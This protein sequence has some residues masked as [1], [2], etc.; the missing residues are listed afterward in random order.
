M[1]RLVSAGALVRDQLDLFVPN[2][3]T[4][5]VGVQAVA[6]SVRVFV[7]NSTMPWVLA[8]GTTVP[9]SSASAG[10]VFVN[11][12]HDSPGFYS[13][14]FF[15]DRVGYWRVVVSIPSL[16]AEVSKDFDVVVAGYF[17]SAPSGSGGLTASFTGQ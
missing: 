11:E 13:V 17:G 7:N 16:S 5:A 15:P 9:D 4:R 1:S 14:R 2:T 8:D 3:G 12:I 6:M 10:T